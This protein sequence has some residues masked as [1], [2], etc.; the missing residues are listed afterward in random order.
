M[1][2]IWEIVGGADKGGILVRDGQ[3][4]KSHALEERLSTGAEVEETEQAGDR[5]K[6]RLKSGSGPPEGWISIRISGK[7]LALPKPSGEVA[8]PAATVEAGGGGKRP[9]LARRVG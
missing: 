5:L 9:G 6:Y 8:A 7:E 1:P 2:Q 3:A 4:L